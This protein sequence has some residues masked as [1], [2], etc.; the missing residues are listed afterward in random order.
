MWG[1]FGLDRLYALYILSFINI[2]IGDRILFNGDASSMKT[3]LLSMAGALAAMVIAAFLFFLLIGALI[4][5]AISSASAKPA[6][7]NEIV[8][9]LDLNTELPDQRPS[10]G[11]AAL[12]ETPGFIDLLVR[13]K[14]AETDDSVKG[15]FIRA[16]TVGVECRKDKDVIDETPAAYKDIDAVMAAQRDLV[17]VVHTLKQVVCVKG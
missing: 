14:A 2:C 8:L 1:L 10:G 16:A 3:F 13:L 5:S 9:S 15:I 4:G 17:E 11:L 12:S 6:Q 7:P